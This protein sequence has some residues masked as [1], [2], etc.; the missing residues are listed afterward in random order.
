LK[1][2]DT[3]VVKRLYTLF[4]YDQSKKNFLKPEYANES[5]TGN[6]RRYGPII[7][8]VVLQLKELIAQKGWP[9]DKLAGVDD[10]N[11]IRDLQLR[12]LDLMDYYNIHNQNNDCSMDPGQYEVDKLEL[13]SRLIMPIL[14]H[15]NTHQG[16]GNLYDTTFYRQ[17]ILL[18]NMHPKDFAIINDD[19]HFMKKEGISP[20]LF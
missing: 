2:L 12:A 17:Q 19:K 20:F 11:V 9:S 1:R 15:H 8:D 5:S 18:G 13:S 3:T 14:V 6:R 16:T 7:T 4:E 10:E